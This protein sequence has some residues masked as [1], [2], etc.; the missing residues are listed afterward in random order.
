MIVI[1]HTQDT[2][3]TYDYIYQGEAIHQMDSF[4]IWACSLL[5][6]NQGVQVLDI[7]TGRGQMVKFARQHGALAYGL[8]FSSTACKIA[9]KDSRGNIINSDAQLL[10]F[11]DH[12]FD[13]ITNFGS[14][15]HFENMDQ[16]IQE[17]A[18]VLRPNG[19]ACLTVPNTFGLRWNVQIAWRTG[20]VDDDGQ[21]LQRYGT[22]QQW[23][24]LLEENGLIIYKIMGY[25]HE[26]AFPRTRKDMINY[27]RH[28]KR[29]ISM[30][31]VAPFVPVNAAG[32]FLFLCKPYEDR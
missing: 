5:S 2:Q 26:R 29:L 31:L 10:P 14:L 24:K 27:F 4:F 1:R 3:K 13:V 15:E 18:R 21:P 20:D 8:D 11:C 25:E 6:I 16:G 23:Q 19:I 22:R 9:N 12:S 32:Q 30:L 28:P 17:M 7:A